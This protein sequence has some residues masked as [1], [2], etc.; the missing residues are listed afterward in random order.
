MTTKLKTDPRRSA[1]MKRVRRSG[2]APEEATAVILRELGIRMR[3]NVKGLPGTPDFANKHRKLVIFVHGC[4]WHG[5]R[6]CKLA[7]LPRRN[8]EF[9]EAK[10]AANRTRDRAKVRALT[11]LGFTVVS[12]WQCELPVVAKRKLCSKLC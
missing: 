10:L 4:F 2:T 8:R 5:H 9:W 1:L 12:L 6:G 11:K 3:R 7:K